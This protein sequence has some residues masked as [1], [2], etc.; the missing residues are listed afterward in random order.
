MPLTLL[1]TPNSLM[2]KNIQFQGG[3]DG[4]S[5]YQMK[6][7][8]LLP[9]FQCYQKTKLPITLSTETELSLSLEAQVSGNSLLTLL[10]MKKIQLILTL[11]KIFHSLINLNTGLISTMDIPSN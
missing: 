7:G 10:T 8:R 5:L 6:T 9:D 2:F 3:S 1:N 11:T 4:A